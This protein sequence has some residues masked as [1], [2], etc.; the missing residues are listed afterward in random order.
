MLPTYISTT[1]W[2]TKVGEC[3]QRCVLAD[4]NI[5]AMFN[6]V[7]IHNLKQRHAEVD[8]VSVAA[9]AAAVGFH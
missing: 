3:M 8:G 2:K 7:K 6:P 5:G 1:K 9:T 4:I